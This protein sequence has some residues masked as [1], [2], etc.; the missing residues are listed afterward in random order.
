M[1]TKFFDNLFKSFSEEMPVFEK[2]DEYLDKEI[3]PKIRP[4][5]EDLYEKEYYLDTRWLEIRD[6][7][8]FHESVLHIFQKDGNY[9]ISVDGNISKGHWKILSKSNTLIL[10]QGNRNE[11]YDLKF[12]NG[13]FFILSKHGN[14]RRKNQR[15]YFVMGRESLVS[16]LEWREIMDLLYSRYQNNSQV[17]VF[18]TIFAIVLVI[19]LGLS[20]F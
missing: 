9:L 16:G 2:M 1:E 7:E 10:D 12:L 15:E 20:F 19:I 6:A 17:I 3:L 8:N 13:D 5:S 4:W 18:V 14:Q 11:L